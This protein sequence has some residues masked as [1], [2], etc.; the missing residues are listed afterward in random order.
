MPGVAGRVA[1]KMCILSL[2][3]GRGREEYGLR[4]STIIRRWKPV[5]E[6]GKRLVETWYRQFSALDT[7]IILYFHKLF[8]KGAAFPLFMASVIILVMIN[9]VITLG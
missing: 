1:T 9:K 6:C 5:G 3:A 8:L 7:Q 4:L 2:I